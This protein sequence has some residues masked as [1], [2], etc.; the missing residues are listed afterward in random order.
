MKYNLDRFNYCNYVIKVCVNTAQEWDSGVVY[1]FVAAI[2]TV[3][4]WQ[5]ANIGLNDTDLLLSC[6]RWVK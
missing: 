2:Y 4:D 5:F 1:Y 3:L 6:R